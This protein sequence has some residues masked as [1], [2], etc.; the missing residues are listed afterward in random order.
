M[1]IAEEKFPFARPPS[2]IGGAIAIKADRKR[3]NPVELL[4]KIRQPLK[5]FDPENRPWHAK[6]F[7]QFPEEWRFVDVEAEN[8]VIE[9]F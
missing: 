2:R 5:R 4:L 7:E 3:G 6:N 8:G 1:E 9:P